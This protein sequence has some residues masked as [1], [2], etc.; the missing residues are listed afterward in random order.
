MQLTDIGY[1]QVQEF[2]NELRTEVS[3]KTVHNTLILLR[4]MLTG[5]RG[6]SAIKRGF[7]RSDPTKGVELPA[8]P[9]RKI[10][11]LAVE[12]VWKLID[13]AEELAASAIRSFSPTLSPA[14]AGMRSWLSPSPM[15][16]GEVTN[17]S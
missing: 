10:Q 8:R 5:K 6:A 2:V 3:A 11:P 16:T 17:W 12:T 14:C 9:H 4:V 7:L 13:A 15:W 1:P